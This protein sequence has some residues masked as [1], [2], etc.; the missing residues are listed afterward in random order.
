MILIQNNTK[1][2]IGENY[3][4]DEG[5]KTEN[6]IYITN[7][8]ISLNMIDDNLECIEINKIAWS[9]WMVSFNRKL[10][11]LE[12]L[13]IRQIAYADSITNKSDKYLAEQEG[14]WTYAL[15]WD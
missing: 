4:Y 3:G 9:D 8:L 11:R 2:I 1:I 5:H 14:I 6:D 10:S 12:E 15:W 7:E 13:G